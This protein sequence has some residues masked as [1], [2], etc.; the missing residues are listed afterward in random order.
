M[1]LDYL[2]AEPPVHKIGKT[3]TFKTGGASFSKSSSSN[4]NPATY[5]EYETYF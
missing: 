3:L 4:S 2:T 1:V 5:Y